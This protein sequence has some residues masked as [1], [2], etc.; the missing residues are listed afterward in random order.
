MSQRRERNGEFARRNPTETPQ[1]F[2]LDPALGSF[3]SDAA[4]NWNKFRRQT[5][6]EAQQT[7]TAD[8]IAS[9]AHNEAVAIAQ[10]GKRLVQRTRQTECYSFTV[11]NDIQPV[12]VQVLEAVT[13]NLRV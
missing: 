12:F 7:Q 6:H 4:P 5:A 3:A 11:K 1:R 10:A 9:K 2:L 8:K 13:K